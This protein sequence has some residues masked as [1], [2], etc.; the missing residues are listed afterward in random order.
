MKI[1]L[2]ILGISFGMIIMV[3][4]ISLYIIENQSK[5][6]LKELSN[7]IVSSAEYYVVG[8]MIEGTSSELL[9]TFPNNQFLGIRGN[10][11]KNGYLKINKEG[12]IELKFH[13]AGYC[14]NKEIGFSEPEITKMSKNECLENNK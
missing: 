5:L 4:L 11:P 13:E 8:K 3:I 2:R 6:S 14:I 1:F 12:K 7:K 9:V 10:V